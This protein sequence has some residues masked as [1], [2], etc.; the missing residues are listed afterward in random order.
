M[1]TAS[2]SPLCEYEPF[3]LGLA[4]PLVK[5]DAEGVSCGIEASSR[6]VWSPVSPIVISATTTASPPSNVLRDT[7]S[8]ET[9]PFPP[10]RSLPLDKRSIRKNGEKH[11]AFP[12]APVAIVTDQ[13]I[14]LSSSNRVTALVNT[15]ADTFQLGRPSFLSRNEFDAKNRAPL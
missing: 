10:A 1:G 6:M 8:E 15:Q 2:E 4:E 14:R 5:F 9:N 7:C 12:H 3:A 13:R 11:D